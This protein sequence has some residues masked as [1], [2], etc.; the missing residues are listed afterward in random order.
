[1]MAFMKENNVDVIELLE[2]EDYKKEKIW[3]WPFLYVIGREETISIFGAKISPEDIEA[4]IYSEKLKDINS[5]TLKL[6][7]N[8]EG[9]TR[10]YILS[11]LKKD[12]T[13]TPEERA[14]LEKSIMTFWFR[15][16]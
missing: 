16:Y 5:F 13:L 9:N 15:N 2:G 11:E 12:F 14:K 10:F 3:R 6:E 7:S 4:A 1:M 8:E